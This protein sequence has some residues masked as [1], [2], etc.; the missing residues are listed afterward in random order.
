MSSP[1]VP[2]T[3]KVVS[4]GSETKSD[5]VCH[6]WGDKLISVATYLKE[7]KA[8]I[9]W[10]RLRLDFDAKEMLANKVSVVN[11]AHIVTSGALKR[12]QLVYEGH[13]VMQYR[14]AYSNDM[15]TPNASSLGLIASLLSQERQVLLKLVTALFV[16]YP[17]SE[18][19]LKREMARFYTL[20]KNGPQV[21]DLLRRSEHVI[22]VYSENNH[23]C[24]DV[25]RDLRSL[26][27]IGS[28]FDH[29]CR[30]NC[31]RFV[32]NGRLRIVALSDI[33][34]GDECTIAYWGSPAIQSSDVN[35]RRA[36]I[37][38]LGGFVCACSLCTRTS[39]DSLCASCGKDKASQRCT[40]CKA[41]YYCNRDCQKKNWKIHKPACSTSASTSSPTPS[42]ISLPDPAL[43]PDP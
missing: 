12:G 6:D 24:D 34:A 7:S 18:D 33:A 40:I 1:A 10:T 41:V 8:A 29:C 14:R 42:A 26:Y 37:Q 39:A 38:S 23:Y 2:H 31:E 3:Q 16:L 27:L 30:P 36:E 43:H 15:A 22:C 17:Y 32:E 11:N 13:A 9:E 35:V 25:D 28:K 20:D 4:I 21:A 5:S 19:D